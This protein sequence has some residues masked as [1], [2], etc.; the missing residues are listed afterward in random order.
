[1]MQL[2][3]DLLSSPMQKTG[4]QRG[5]GGQPVTMRLAGVP[6]QSEAAGTVGDK[7]PA[8]NPMSNG[9]GQEVSPVS[10]KRP[11][12][13]GQRNPS[14]HATVPAV[15]NVPTKKIGR[16][17]EPWKAEGDVV[18]FAWRVVLA[19]G[20]RLTVTYSPEVGADRVRQD[21][22]G[23]TVEPFLDSTPAPSTDSEGDDATLEG[24]TWADD[25]R[26]RCTHCLNLRHGGVCKVAAPGGLVS[27]V[28]GYRPN[29]AALHRCSGYR[30]CPDDPDQRPGLERWQGLNHKWGE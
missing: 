23:A 18:H 26:R 8:G 13:W 25:D 28:H 24:I 10:P 19:D 16:Q 30:P 27:A 7:L 3:F 9:D 5:Q 2:D 17:H 14:I 15:P 1:M 29:Q 11:Y 22:P 4:G 6:K 20:M 12:D 21:Y